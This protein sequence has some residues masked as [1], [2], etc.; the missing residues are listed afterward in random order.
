MQTLREHFGGELVK[1]EQPSKAAKS[2][3]KQVDMSEYV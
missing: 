1:A 2:T 3:S